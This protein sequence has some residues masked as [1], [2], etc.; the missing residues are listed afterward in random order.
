MSLKLTN[1]RQDECRTDDQPD[2]ER[3]DGASCDGCRRSGCRRKQHGGDGPARGKPLRKENRQCQRQEDAA[4]A[5]RHR[6]VV[7]DKHLAVDEADGEEGGKRHDEEH[8]ETV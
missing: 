3:M 7:P 8:H 1:S 6:Q 4:A 2:E 5:K